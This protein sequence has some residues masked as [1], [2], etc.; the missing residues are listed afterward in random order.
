MAFIVPRAAA[1]REVLSIP[2]GPD[3]AVPLA[4]AEVVRRGWWSA[5]VSRPASPLGRVLILRQTGPWADSHRERREPREEVENTGG[6]S[7]FKSAKILLADVTPVVKPTVGAG[8]GG[9]YRAK[10]THVGRS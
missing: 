6:F 9:S 7:S 4:L 5:G 1:G 3:L 10:D 2:T 8:G